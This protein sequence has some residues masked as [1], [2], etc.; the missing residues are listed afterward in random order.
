MLRIEAPAK[1]NWFLKITGKREDGYHSLITLMQ[2]ISLYDILEFEPAEKIEVISDL[3]IPLEENYIYKAAMLLKKAYSIRKGARIF[4]KKNI[5]IAAGL[6]GGSSDA[7]HTLIGL[8]K[9]WSIG[10]RNK[11]LMEL[12][13]KLGSDV[14]FFLAGNIAL[15]EGFGEKVTPVDMKGTLILLIVKPSLSIST[16]W[17]Y[18]AFDKNTKLTKK[19][20]DIKLLIQALND[21]DFARLATLTDNEL[22]P[23]VISSYPVVKELKENLIESGALFSSMT[24]SGSSVYGVFHDI[25]M[26]EKASERFDSEWRRIVKTLI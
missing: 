3:N 16:A 1:I 25:E 5:P 15:V 23:A 13:F 6:G 26:A 22:E 14:P 19:N 24:G 12:S 4:L 7:A 10:I 11:E 21:R 9:L 20:I 2:C 18:S 8:N 17:A